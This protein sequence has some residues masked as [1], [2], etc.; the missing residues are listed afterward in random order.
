MLACSHEVI[1]VIF[2]FELTGTQSQ[3]EAL[4]KIF[5]LSVPAPI[6]TKKQP[7]DLVK[8]WLGVGAIDATETESLRMRGRSR[9]AVA[10]AAMPAA[11]SRKYNSENNTERR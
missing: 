9:T 8:M 2:T 5:S 1:T 10:A 7:T 4:S 6:S 11:E 3:F